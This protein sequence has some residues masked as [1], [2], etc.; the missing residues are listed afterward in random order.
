MDKEEFAELTKLIMEGTADCVIVPTDWIAGIEQ[1]TGQL[2]VDLTDS[3]TGII[4][5]DLIRE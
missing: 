5:K 3:Y 1:L 2:L 4:K